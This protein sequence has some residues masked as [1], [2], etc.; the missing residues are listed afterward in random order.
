MKK[1]KLVTVVAVTAALIGVGAFSGCK[2]E[3]ISQDTLQ[4][5]SRT[6]AEQK[7]KQYEKDVRPSG[8]VVEGKTWNW[9]VWCKNNDKIYVSNSTGSKKEANAAAKEAGKNLDCNPSEGSVD[10]GTNISIMSPFSDDLQGSLNALIVND[11]I[12]YIDVIDIWTNEFRRFTR[13]DISANAL[14]WLSEICDYNE[15]SLTT[16]NKVVAQL[17]VW[18]VYL[19]GN[20]VTEIISLHNLTA[21]R[22]NAIATKSWDKITI[23]I[24][25]DEDEDGTIHLDWTFEY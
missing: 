8:L 7:K 23:K 6:A 13:N 9:T 10:N 5:T 3:N 14:A 11:M 1:L 2:K 20:S 15:T 18:G 17:K 12:V 24:E 4:E 16:V 21:E 22:F 19:G 25:E